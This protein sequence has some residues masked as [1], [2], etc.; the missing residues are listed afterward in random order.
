MSAD[1]SCE[2][3]LQ[4]LFDCDYVFGDPVVLPGRS[5]HT[6]VQ[7]EL[8]GAV[9]DT[10]DYIYTL[11][12]GDAGVRDP[13]AWKDVI[14][15]KDA[16]FLED[17]KQRIPGVYSFTHYRIKLQTG[18]RIYYS[19]PLHTMGK[20]RYMDWR[21]QQAI[22]RAE[23]VALAARSGIKGTIL[24]RKISGFPC[25]RCRDFNT[26]E[27]RDSNCPI[28]YGTGFVGG[29]Y[30]PVECCWFE[31]SQGSSTI[32][33]DINMQGTVTPTTLQARAIAAPILVTGD[34]WINRQNSE[35]YKIIQVK[36]IVEA[37]G[38]PAVY[39]LAIDRLPFSDISYKVGNVVP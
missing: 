38:V 7:W 2:N 26:Q 10:G 17:A 20:L 16:Y 35:R 12:F 39:Q 34:I 31:V 33:Q 30:A 6:F 37:K 1:I 22:M 25:K 18:E 15:E 28:C 3:S 5:G 21:L 27:V 32:V 13:I 19:R 29:Y 14:S 36:S 23:S 9:R 11:Q 4:C 24:K 8:S